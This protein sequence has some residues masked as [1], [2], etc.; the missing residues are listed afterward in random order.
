MY[1]EAVTRYADTRAF[2]AAL[3]H[4]ETKDLS[5]LEQKNE[6]VAK[7]PFWHSPGGAVVIG[8]LILFGMAIL[9]LLAQAFR[10]GL[11]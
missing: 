2:L 1:N 4:L 7:T 3:D 5:I 6:D 8:F 9:G 11:H 10:A